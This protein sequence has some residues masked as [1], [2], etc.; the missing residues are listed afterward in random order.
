MKRSVAKKGKRIRYYT[1]WGTMTVLLSAS[2]PEA[3]IL[4][5]DR[6]ADFSAL[7]QELDV[8]AEPDEKQNGIGKQQ[9]AGTQTSEPP[10]E[11]PRGNGPAATAKGSAVYSDE[12]MITAGAGKYVERS[13]AAADTG[14]K[15]TAAVSSASGKKGS[16]EKNRLSDFA[17]AAR[18]AEEQSGFSGIDPESEPV[19]AG[20]APE[21]ESPVSDLTGESDAE[22]APDADTRMAEV[23]RLSGGG[24]AEADE[25]MAEVARL[26]GEEA[27]EEEARMA[28]LSELSGGGATEADERMAEVA[29]LSGADLSE[30]DLRMTELAK[31]SEEYEKEMEEKY[32]PKIEDNIVSDPNDYRDGDRV[33]ATSNTKTDSVITNRVR[34]RKDPEIQ[35]RSAWKK[36]S[37]EAEQ[38]AE[39]IVEEFF[40]KKL[41]EPEDGE[42]K[43]AGGS[44]PALNMEG[45][46]TGL[47]ESVKEFEASGAKKL[48]LGTFKL[49]AYDACLICCGKTD[50]ITATGTHATVGRTIAVDPDIIP[51][52]SRVMIG[53]HVYVAEDCGGLIKGKKIDIYMNTHQEALQFGVKQAE[54]F[55]VREGDP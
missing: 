7:V 48:S 4:A 15:K 11:G 14:T 40:G 17:K 5:A 21:G 53:D 10:K 43:G 23:A 6:L 35:Q 45:F 55:L 32:G 34:E 18:T 22:E 42:E 19:E 3:E 9:E 37:S 47:K 44:E 26:S 33:V 29:R 20:A 52:G 54:V 25:R 1:V 31:Q 28:E 41:S 49:T 8:Q 24:A 38:E 16:D 36:G 39:N 50:G 30:G 51:Y 46:F 13:G 2:A 27:D 12:Y